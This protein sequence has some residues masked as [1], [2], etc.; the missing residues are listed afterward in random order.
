M[1]VNDHVPE[2]RLTNCGQRRDPHPEACPQMPENVNVPEEPEVTY[3]DD[4]D[5]VNEDED[6]DGVDDDA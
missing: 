4:D 2:R 5:H 1:H 6:D 3:Y